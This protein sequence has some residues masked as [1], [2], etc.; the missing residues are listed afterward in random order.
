M[1]TYD[2]NW[3]NTVQ[4]AE[5]Q[6]WTDQY[7]MTLDNDKGDV[8]GNGC[9]FTAHYVTG[10]VFK[11]ISSNE[12]ARI[13]KVYQNNFKFPGTLMRAP[14][15]PDDREAHDDYIGMMSADAQ[16]NPPSNRALTRAMFEA[17]QQP[18]DGVDETDSDKIALNKT[19]YGLLKVL[20]LG[21]VRC[22]WNNVLKNKFH[23]SSWLQ[24]R[25][26]MM[27]TMQMSLRERVNP[28]YWLWWASTMI[29]WAKTNADPREGILQFHMAKTCYGYGY[30][31][32]RVCEMV[33]NK[34][35]ASGGIGKVIGDYFGNTNH[36]L[37]NLLKD[38]K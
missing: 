14:S 10:M 5:F 16:L 6:P 33:E 3:I 7:G 35:V 8:G 4:F 26:E 38:I 11:G 18:C 32:N 37:V 19:L 22:T 20:F 31:T 34:M 9:L 21:K 24:R 27:A 17:G 1:P 28:V 36:P 15:K 2:K 29:L 30:L 23:V 13:L 25:M 12:K